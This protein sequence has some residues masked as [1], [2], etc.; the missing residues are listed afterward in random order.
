MDLQDLRNALDD[1]PDGL[2]ETY[3]RILAGV[4]PRS[5]EKAI[6]MLQLLVWAKRELTLN[7]LVDAL[8]IRQGEERL[9]YDPSTK[10]PVPNELIKILPGLI[11]LDTVTEFVRPLLEGPLLRA[12]VRVWVRLAHFS[13]KEYLTSNG[14]HETF[15][16]SLRKLD[17]HIAIVDMC[18]AHFYTSYPEAHV[19]DKLKD[20]QKTGGETRDLPYFVYYLCHWIG[21]AR[22]AQ[23]DESA[24]KRIAKVLTSGL[25]PRSPFVNCIR[26]SRHNREK[27]PSRPD[28]EIGDM[29]ALLYASECGLDCVVT[30]LLEHD[31]RTI[32]SRIPSDRA[33]AL[34]VATGQCHEE[35]VRTLLVNGATPTM[36]LVPNADSYCSNETASALRILRMLLDYGAKPTYL[37]LVDAVEIHNIQVVQFLLD[38][39]A[40]MTDNNLSHPFEKLRDETLL[41]V[42]RLWIGPNINTIRLLLDYGVDIN[43]LN[44]HHK[45]AL[46]ETRYPE[47]M[48]LLLERVADT[49]TP[50]EG[51]NPLHGSVIYER[52]H[53][54]VS[55]L[56][57]GADI[58]A[59]DNWG[60]TALH[61]A[62]IWY[63]P[64]CSWFVEKLLSRGAN[65]LIKD[66]L[67]S[68]ALD[69]IHDGRSLYESSEDRECRSRICSMLSKAMSKQSRSTEAV[70]RT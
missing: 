66:H 21:H 35:T 41:H 33:T 30:R 22:I 38:N 34:E 36:N 49:N 26:F 59:Q 69:A 2:D 47:I 6:A 42:A 45:T 61:V 39:G 54:F 63:R 29:T 17:A 9:H 23:T 48:R 58:D 57:N 14:A 16:P 46:D 53:D 43:A 12:R 4:H 18:I 68:S 52:Q 1:L 40:P 32:D 5:Q 19:L 8:A 25:D 13:V 50:Y 27:H 62:V 11:V 65:A 28:E 31:A 20:S 64:S 3:S 51:H 56:D 10:M 70:S 67:G 7:E 15:K 44:K 24:S 60:R 37:A 55:L